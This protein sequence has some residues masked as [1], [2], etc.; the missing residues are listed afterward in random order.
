MPH[1]VVRAASSIR[2]LAIS[3]PTGGL[4]RPAVWELTAIGLI[5]AGAAALRIY[6]L[7]SLPYG[8]SG[9]EATVGLEGERVLHDGWIGPY[10]PYA[11][12]QPAGVLYA[13]AVPLALFGKSFLALRLEPAMAGVLTVAAVYVVG[14]RNFGIVTALAAAALL[15][16]STWAIH[17]SRLAIPLGTWPLVGVL[18]AGSLFEALRSGSP[19]WWA[20]AGVFAAAG[21]YVYD[22]HNVFLAVIACFLVGVAFLRRKTLRPVVTGAAVMAGTFVLVA[23]PM[24]A[25]IA[26]H[27][28][29]YT[30]HARYNTVLDDPGWSEGGV[31]AKARFLA[32][33]YVDYWDNLCCNPRPDANDATGYARLV[34]PLFLALAALG[35]ILGLAYRRGPPVALGLVIVL[36]MPVASVVS[37]GG[38][39]R[40]GFVMLPFLALFAGLAIDVTSA[41][42]AARL[43]IGRTYAA[44]VAL[45]FALAILAPRG[46]D[47]YFGGFRGSEEEHFTFAPELTNVALYLRDLRRDTH[48]YFFSARAPVTH[49]IMR[50]L[51][52]GV[53]AED[54]SREFGASEG[55]AIDRAAGKPVFVLMDAYLP[56]LTDIQRRY[57]GGRTYVLDGARGSVQYVAYEPPP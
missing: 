16:V 14:R 48:V 17:F 38:M 47:G 4:G 32:S 12:G 24:L 7:G 55:L 36:V 54:R 18:V 40:R 28:D 51:A 43:R 50:Y 39:A 21:M 13:T 3:R 34:P 22:A 2:R 8:I 45:A 29:A 49:E 46:I 35:I 27:P 15:A 42:V 1:P 19:R 30:G 26:E 20:A 33:R 9:D 56:R 53:S 25:W 31:V 37:E 41:L 10:S 11:M 52:P 23:L 5:L 6:D 57:P 44:A